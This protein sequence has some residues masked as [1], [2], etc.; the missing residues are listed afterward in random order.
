MASVMISSRQSI[1]FPFPL[2]LS[3]SSGN[4]RLHKFSVVKESTGKRTPHE[5]INTKLQT[6]ENNYLLPETLC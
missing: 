2:H 4:E 3:G 1:P 6:N 5:D